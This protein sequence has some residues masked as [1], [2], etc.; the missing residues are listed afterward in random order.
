MSVLINIIINL[1]LLFFMYHYLKWKLLNKDEK[2]SESGFEAEAESLIIEINRT[3]ERNL[4]LIEAKIKQLKEEVKNADK[5]VSVINKEKSGNADESAIYRKLETRSL[6]ENAQKTDSDIIK[7]ELPHKETIKNTTGLEN[8]DNNIITDSND[9]RERAVKMY[10]NGIE[11]ELI[12][13]NLD[14]PVG[15]IELMISLDK[16]GKK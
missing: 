15:E 16:A 3:T 2:G 13:R 1:I 8:T 4:Q 11:I 5:V 14:I 7:V 9:I 6:F 12:S 10:K